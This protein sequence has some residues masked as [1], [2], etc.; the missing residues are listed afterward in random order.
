MPSFAPPP[1]KPLGSSAGGDDDDSEGPVSLLTTTMKKKKQPAKAKGASAFSFGAAAAAAAAAPAPPPVA[2]SAPG[3]AAAT[4]AAEEDDDVDPLEAFMSGIDAQAKTQAH[5][6]VGRQEEFNVLAKIKAREAREEEE[7]EEEEP[8]FVRPKRPVK[9]A[10]K[11]GKAGVGGATAVK[12]GAA[13]PKKQRQGL[14]FSLAQ[15]EALKKKVEKQS[16]SSSDDDDD[17]DGGSDDDTFGQWHIPGVNRMKK[18]ELK[19]VDHASIDYPDFRKNF[20][21]EARDVKRRPQSVDDAFYKAHQVKVRGKNVPK[22]ALAF[23]QFGLAD[24]ILKVVTRHEW[25]KPL[26]VQAICMPIIMSGRDCIGIAKTG[27]GKTLAFVLPMLRHIKDQPDLE[28]DDGPLALIMAPTRELAIQLFNEVKH[29]TKI[30]DL[31][32][33]CVYG[34]PNG[35][36]GKAGSTDT[37]A[38]A[39]PFCTGGA[40]VAEQIG[41]L[42]FGVHIIVCTP[43]RM[44]DLLCANSGRV[45]NLRRVTYVCMDEADR[46]FDM[47]FEPQIMKILSNTRPDR[48][49]VL[50]SATF[51]PSVEKLAKT[52]L[53]MPIEVTVGTRSTVNTD[54]KQLIEVRNPCTRQLLPCGPT[55]VG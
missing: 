27:S 8:A 31:R 18:K 21:I 17:E 13:P 29:F 28:P 11:R 19:Q 15:S 33:A 22:P 34:E 24:R 54:V 53:S 9:K 38:S 46:M 23:H 5:Q 10:L 14:S 4:L 20:Y 7:E 30:L 40:G 35:C 2:A 36:I 48:Q 47:G 25:E 41:A 55:G 51:P 52:V 37:N 44:I 16:E 49:T 39:R 50:F 12:L 43:G 45:T 1:L 3:P 42:K 32:A 26:P 6:A